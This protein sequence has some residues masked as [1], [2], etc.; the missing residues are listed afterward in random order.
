MTLESRKPRYRTA[1]ESYPE[2]GAMTGAYEFICPYKSTDD[3][4]ARL[5]QLGGW[6]WQIG[7]SH[8]Y[9]DYVACLPFAGVRI[10]I[11]D[12]PAK[13]GNEYKYQADIKR[14]PD[15]KTQMPAIDEAFRKV[16]AQ[17]PAHS[18]KEIEWFD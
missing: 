9:G 2:N 1:K 17:I 5:N 3:L 13:V 10:R 6:Q 16:L 15:C 18:V 14:S 8:W 7:D 11:C 4:Y 12:F